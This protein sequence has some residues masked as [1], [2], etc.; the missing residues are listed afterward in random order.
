[1][2]SS[3]PSKT[4]TRLSRKN[5]YPQI[6]LSFFNSVRAQLLQRCFINRFFHGD[7]GMPGP[8]EPPALE[9]EQYVHLLLCSFFF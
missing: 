8:H 1:M 4:K 9:A 3:T 5:Y 7:L 2:R 6:V